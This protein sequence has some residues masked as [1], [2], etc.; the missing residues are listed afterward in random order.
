M[1]RKPRV[2]VI[3][4]GIGGI[5][6]AA[7]LRKLGVEVAVYERASDLG[8]VGAGVQIG[9]NGVKDLRALGLDPGLEGLAFEPTEI[10]SVDWQTASQRFRQPLRAIAA[11]QFGA[12]YI[13][14][15]RADVHRLLRA[16]VPDSVITLNA[17]CTAV[18]SSDRGAVA[19]FADGSKVEADLI[20]GADGIRSVVREC[21][22][23]AVPARFTEQIGWRAILPIELVPTRVGPDKS[24]RIERTEYVGWIGPVGHV[25]C[26]P[27]RG[28]NLY[29]MFVG[30]VSSEWAEESWTAPSNKEEMLTAFAGWNEALLG[31]LSNVQHVFKWG[32]YDR[33]P[34]TQWTRGRVTLLGDAAHPMMPTLAQGA[35]ITLEDAYTFARNVARYANDPTAALKAYESERID[36]ARRVQLQARDQFNNNR[37]QPA[38]PPLSRDWIFQHDATAEPMAL[39][40]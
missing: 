35:S 2:I 40:G 20:V 30:R 17:R 39:A 5:A 4:A 23:G 3:G 31:M 16:K 26:Y 29:N 36:R 18:S 25:I 22:F 8:E 13:T 12:P 14:A 19:T 34:L 10:V 21:L 28:G 27:I 9:P 33:D 6:A 32:I 38:P 11:K 24:V 1:Q 15:H 7:A 37:K